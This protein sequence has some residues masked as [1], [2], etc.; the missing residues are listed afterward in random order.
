MHVYSATGLSDADADAGAGERIE[1]VRRPLA[2]L[3]G[4]IAGCRDAK[5]IIGLGWLMAE[6]GA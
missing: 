6:R 4:V 2:E 3:A 5:T 1:I